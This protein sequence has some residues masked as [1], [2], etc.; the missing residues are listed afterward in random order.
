LQRPELGLT[1]LTLSKDGRELK[2]GDESWSHGDTPI[3][4]ACRAEPDATPDSG[5]PLGQSRAA[6]LSAAEQ[7]AYGYPPASVK[8]KSSEKAQAKGRSHDAPTDMADQASEHESEHGKSKSWISFSGLK[9]KTPVWNKALGSSTMSTIAPL[10]SADPSSI[11]SSECA[12]EGEAPHLAMPL[13][14]YLAVV[15]DDTEDESSPPAPQVRRAAEEW[16]LTDESLK[17]HLEF[18]LCSVPEERDKGT[19]FGSCSNVNPGRQMYP[20]S[21]DSVVV[22]GALHRENTLEQS[23]VIPQGNA[24]DL[25]EEIDRLMLCSDSVIVRM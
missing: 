4:Q 2:G 17:R 19:S 14:E 6:E 13:A 3:I 16:P 21:P 25:R 1:I 8:P 11:A 23:V 18:L 22:M 10:S 5:K 7:L 15:K 20:D 24:K 12:S 9:R